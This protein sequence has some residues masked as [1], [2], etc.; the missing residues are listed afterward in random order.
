MTLNVL[1]G[2]GWIVVVLKYCRCFGNGFFLPN[3]RNI[4]DRHVQPH[5]VGYAI[6]VTLFHSHMNLVA[7]PELIMQAFF[8]FFSL[9]VKFSKFY[10]GLGNKII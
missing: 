2:H 9:E 8:A 5:T 1:K 6:Q 10:K 3:I 7:L 4:F